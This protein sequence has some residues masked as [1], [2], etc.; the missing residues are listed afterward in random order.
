MFTE[1]R[2]QI[3]AFMRRLYRQG[4][5]TTSGGNISWRVSDEYVL[6]T[7]SKI[8]K[9]ELQ[10]TDI[11]V[12]TTDGEN[13]TPEL[14]PSI[15]TEMHLSIY[16]T[17]PDARA[18]VHA[19]PLAA[20]ALSAT[21]R[22]INCRYIAESYAIVGTPVR[23]PYAMM[24]T[25]DLAA[26]VS[27]AA[28]EGNCIILDN[29]GVLAIGITLLEAFDRLEVLE[30]AAQTMLLLHAQGEA[31]ELTAEQLTELDVLMQRQ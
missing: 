25:P 5:T 26:S 7:P 13:L 4:L 30:R 14:P 28:R 17:R 21:R 31:R 15:E 24:G 10:G 2:K 29:H 23:A 1:E 3:A 8:D 11:G 12:L 9:G 27:Q 18:V 22:E 20:T 16:R 19:H 6:L